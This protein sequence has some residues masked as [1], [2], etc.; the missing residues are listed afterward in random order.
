MMNI[1]IKSQLHK[2]FGF[3]DLVFF[4]SLF[5]SFFFFFFFSFFFLHYGFHGNQYK[6]AVDKNVWVIKDFL[7]KYFYRRFV[8]ISANASQKMLFFNFSHYKSVAIATTLMSQ[9]F[10]KHVHFYKP[11]QR[12]PQMKFGLQWPRGFRGN[13]I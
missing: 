2:G 5:V 10:Y 4:L 8:K 1:S 7:K 6:R 11:S 9:F 13:V 3:C 12:V